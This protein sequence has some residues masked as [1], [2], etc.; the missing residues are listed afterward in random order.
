MHYS[1]CDVLPV[2]ELGRYDKLINVGEGYVVLLRP[3]S[4]EVRVDVMLG[5]YMFYRGYESG[6][7]ALC[8]PSGQLISPQKDNTPF[9][10]VVKG[11]QSHAEFVE[12]VKQAVSEA[13]LMLGLVVKNIR[14]ERERQ[15][16]VGDEGRKAVNEVA[17][18]LSAH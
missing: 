13:K 8:G 4:D 11:T 2:L 18:A 15:D 9:R 14:Q 10:R 12:Q 16:E 6:V 7:F 1:K 3:A 5:R 17:E